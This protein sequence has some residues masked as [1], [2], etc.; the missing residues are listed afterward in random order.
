MSA[1]DTIHALASRLSIEYEDAAILR[2]CAMTLHRWAE[3]ECGDGNDTSSWCIER[4][5]EN[6]KPYMVRHVYAI[7]RS[8]RSPIPD[9]E[10]G[11][12]KRVKAVCE[13]CGLHYYHQTDPRGLALYVARGPLTAENYPLCGIAV[14]K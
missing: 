13:R 6:G 1:H 9:R 4:D 8:I 7:G 11:A 10:A 3:L 2:R 14:M 12:L 5:E